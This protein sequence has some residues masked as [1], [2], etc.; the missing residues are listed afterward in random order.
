MDLEIAKIK[1]KLL[2]IEHG[3]LQ[4]GWKFDFSRQKFGLGLCNYRKKTIFLSRHYTE[5]NPWE[6]EMKDT[7]LHEIAHVLTPGHGHDWIWKMKCKEIGANPNR[8]A[9]GD[10]LEKPE[11]NPER[12]YKAVCSCGK[13]Y[14]MQRKGKYFNFYRCRVCKEKLVFNPNP[15]YYNWASAAKGS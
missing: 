5:I 6:P 1:A 2:M 4:K 13:I 12:K 15:A 7:V 8:L 11:R 14:R 9:T 3:I 10:N